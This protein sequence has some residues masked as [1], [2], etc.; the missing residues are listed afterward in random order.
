M[1]NLSKT[2]KTILFAS[3]IA[4]MILPF[5]GMQ[6]AEAQT[7]DSAYIKLVKQQKSVKDMSEEQ[8]TKF[9]KQTQ[10]DME[11]TPYDKQVY[12][13]LEK[14]SKL[15]LQIID[16]EEKGK[17]TTKLIEKGWALV[18]ELENYGVVNEDRLL[19][20]KDFW[21]E[22]SDQASEQ[23]RK[24]EIVKAVIE[25]TTTSNIYNIHT[26]DV[27]LKNQS[28]ID[29][30]CGF[31]LGIPLYCPHKDIEWGGGSDSHAIKSLPHSGT[32][33]ME[34]KICTEDMGGH[35]GVNFTFDTEHY[36]KS[37]FGSTVFDEDNGPANVTIYVTYGCSYY[38]ESYGG[39]SAVA[40][41]TAHTETH[42]DTTVTVVG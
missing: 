4:A 19:N 30:V 21:H 12:K 23:I 2:T 32:V 25:S 13:I 11:A 1:K 34:G 22:R 3:L 27:S 37:I 31:F 6:G 16:A 17:D 38:K 20:N 40:G 29:Y 7:E 28:E 8:R 15:N 18:Y 35:S 24:G 5:S 42:L 26:N 39:I 33:Y 14:L 41:S 9:I 36:V 10:D